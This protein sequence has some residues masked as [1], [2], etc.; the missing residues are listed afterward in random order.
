MQTHAG[1]GRQADYVTGI[2]R[3]FWLVKNNMNQNSK[4]AVVCVVRMVRKYTVA[5][6]CLLQKTA[7]RA[8]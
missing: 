4:F 1:I 7:I 6:P 8:L 5:D 2:G 3:Y